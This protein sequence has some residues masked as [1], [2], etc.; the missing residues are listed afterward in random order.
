MIGGSSKLWDRKPE[1]WI[2]SSRNVINRY[3]YIKWDDGYSY[4]NDIHKW[5]RHFS[6]SWWWGIVIWR[7]DGWWLQFLK[8][9]L[10]TWDQHARSQR[11]RHTEAAAVLWDWQETFFFFL[12]S[13]NFLAMV[14][15]TIDSMAWEVKFCEHIQSLFD[16]TF[17]TYLKSHNNKKMI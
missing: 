6:F 15:P 17:Y 9:I 8:K 12:L 13:R 11:G 5:I 4:W 14:F 10:K 16:L 7:V 2:W 3:K 1:T